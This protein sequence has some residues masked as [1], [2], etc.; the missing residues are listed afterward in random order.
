MDHL[1]RSRLNL[2]TSDLLN[3]DNLVRLEPETLSQR[4]MSDRARFIGI[5]RMKIAVDDNRN[6]G[7]AWLTRE[8]TISHNPAYS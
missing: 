3:R 2:L 7:P 4:V 8:E 1:Q 6:P 5:H